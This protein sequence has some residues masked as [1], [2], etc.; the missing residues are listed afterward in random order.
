MA[1]AISATPSQASGSQPVFRKPIQITSPVRA[2]LAWPKT[3][4]GGTPTP[5]VRCRYK[6]PRLTQVRS[7]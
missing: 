6:P 7:M 4:T 2:T 3:S 5:V 1:A